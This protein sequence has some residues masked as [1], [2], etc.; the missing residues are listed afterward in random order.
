M[1]AIRQAKLLLGLLWEKRPINEAVESRVN[2]IAVWHVTSRGRYK[3]SADHF[4]S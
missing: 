1:A 2:I 4:I 3:R